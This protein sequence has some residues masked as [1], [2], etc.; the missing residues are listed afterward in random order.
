MLPLLLVIIKIQIFTLLKT[1]RMVTKRGN[2]VFW[3]LFWMGLVGLSLYFY[4]TTFVDYIE[5]YVPPN[6]KLG[7]WFSKIWFIGHIA[8]A[9]AALLLGPLQ[10]WGRFRVRYPKYHRWAGKVFVVGSLVAAVGAF[11]LNLLYDCVACRVS[12]GILSVLWF[13]FTAVAWWAIR[14]RNVQTHR[15]FMVR[16]YTAALAFVF[17]RL[18]PLFGYQTVFPF[19]I[20]QLERR[21][22]AEWL[23]WIVPL[24]VV[25]LY[26]VWWP[27]LATTPGRR[28]KQPKPASV[29]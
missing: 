4:V 2:T 27:Q 7:F 11:R 20:T 15:Q 3:A 9:S 5:G 16:S 17:I 10:F 24:V 22:T 25:E 26:M 21:I 28:P 13:W 1:T 23:C 14:H 19:L 29:A 18:F 8:G 6:F 12:L